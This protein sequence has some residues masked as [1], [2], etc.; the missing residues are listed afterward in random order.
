M[1]PFPAEE[2]L[3]SRKW[4]QMFEFSLRPVDAELRILVLWTLS[5][6]IIVSFSAHFATRK[7]RDVKLLSG[8][9]VAF[10]TICNTVTALALPVPIFHAFY[11]GRPTA[12]ALMVLFVAVGASAW[13]NSILLQ[14]LM[15]VGF[16]LV[17]AKRRPIRW[18]RQIGSK[19]SRRRLS[20]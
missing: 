4:G 20:K 14:M 17:G 3:I 8:F 1:N 15:N 5:T 9:G 11:S 6:V 13:A 18:Y 19:R 7:S 2:A 12:A 10:A 16:R